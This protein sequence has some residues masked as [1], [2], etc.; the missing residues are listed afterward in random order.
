MRSCV[1]VQ[2]CS[3]DS[4]GWLD[5]M[6][7]AS[8]GWC[9]ARSVSCRPGAEGAPRSGVWLEWWCGESFDVDVLVVLVG[10]EAAGAT[11][12]DCLFF[13]SLCILLGV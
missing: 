13:V 10:W 4:S 7:V 3:R 8:A 6:A 9:E 5:V 1:L 2:F 12:R 11:R